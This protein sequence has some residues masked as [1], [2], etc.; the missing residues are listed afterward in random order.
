MNWLS[1]LLVAEAMADPHFFGDFPALPVTL[2]DTGT[3]IVD[4]DAMTLT[5]GA[6]VHPGALATDGVVVFSFS[7][8]DLT[9]L[10]AT[11]SRPFAILS[12]Q[13]L[14]VRGDL[15]VSAVSTSGPGG[16]P[17]GSAVGAGGSGPGGGGAD[18]GGA[19]GGAA[20]GYGGTGGEGGA[21]GI[22]YQDPFTQLE[23][24]S[25]GARS[26]DTGGVNGVGGHGG[27]AL[28]LGAARNLLFTTNA[29]LLARGSAGQAGA[30]DGGGGGGGGMLLLH[31]RYTSVCPAQVDLDVRGGNGGNGGDDGGGGGSGGYALVL[32]FSGCSGATTGGNGGSGNAWWEDG[33]AA[34]SGYKVNSDWNYDGDAYWL[35]TDCD[36]GDFAVHPGATEIAG[37]GID[38]NCNFMEACYVDADGDGFR[39]ATV[40]AN[41]T[42]PD[43]DDLGE[44]LASDPVDCNDADATISPAA[45][46]VPDDG[47]NGDCSGG[48]TCFVDD[49]NDGA[50]TAATAPSADLDCTDAREGRTGDPIDCDD[51]TAGRSPTTLELVADGVDQDCVGGDTCYLDGDGDGAGGTGVTLSADLDCTDPGEAASTTDCDDLDP[52]VSPTATEITGDE[53]DQNCNGHESCWVDGDGDG[54]RGTGTLNSPDTDCDDAGEAPTTAPSDCNDQVATIEPGATELVGDGVDQDCD[55][56]EQCRVDGDGDGFRHATGAVTSADVDCADAGEALASAAVDC[57]DGDG[58]IN[59]GA[60]EQTCDGEDDDCDPATLDEPD[61]DGDGHAV[62]VDCDDAEAAVHPGA[63][64]V[65]NG[66]DDDCVGGPDDKLPTSTWYLDGD[67]DGYGDPLTERVDCYGP[68]AGSVDNGGDCDD[69]AELVSPEGTEVGCNG[70]DEDCDPDLT[71]DQ[72]DDDHDGFTACEAE[73]CDDRAADAFPGAAEDCDGRDTNCDGSFDAEDLDGDGVTVCDGDCWDHDLDLPA[74][75]VPCNGVDDDCA[76]GTPDEVDDDLDGASCDDCDDGDPHVF[77]GAPERACNG[78]DDDCERGTSDVVDGDLDGA[79]CDDCDD[80]D[81]DVFP[82]AEDPACDDLDED[83]DP[84]TPAECAGTSGDTASQGGLTKDPGCGCDG[85]GGAGGW[86]A[87]AM[88]AAAAARRR[89]RRAVTP[90]R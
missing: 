62:C 69:E 74:P 30:E 38:Q 4:T 43:C 32:G 9:N 59:P 6:T 8:V 13:D 20:A 78:V 66:R 15:N 25:G 36:D 2:V 28:E 64:E 70:V 44:F 60:T 80:T 51:T 11:G 79:A 65:C 57:N 86:G 24:G 41:S 82:G 12:A 35:S 67:A 18:L 83:C 52:G 61:G 72:T 39:S 50:R 73:D 5:S 21:G 31:G 88:V 87:A 10:T 49:D 47:V 23:G 42:D 29:N 14:D 81:P 16:F 46:E 90:R 55:G 1:T 56:A 71:P 76:P 84:G 40:T 45:T 63:Q 19:G 22:L 89:S 27:G 33:D 48:D 68:Q 53:L 7:D 3:V 34:W 37:D 58:A 85:A 77:P 17:G 54:S 26:S 75:E